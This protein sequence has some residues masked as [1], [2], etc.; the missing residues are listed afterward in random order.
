LA[1]ETEV[2]GENLPQ[3]HFVHHK[4]RV[5]IS[6]EQRNQSE[7]DARWKR[8]STVKSEVIPEDKSL[9]YVST[10]IYCRENLNTRQYFKRHM[11]FR[12]ADESLVS[13]DKT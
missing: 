13:S 10:I 3:C 1:G 12:R 9:V 8:S 5:E 2:L 4:S 6:S 7:D 11:A